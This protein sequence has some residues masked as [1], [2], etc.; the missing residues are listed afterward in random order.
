MKIVFTPESDRQASEKERWWREHRPAS[1]TLFADELS[2]VLDLIAHTPNVGA[3]YQTVSGRH[4][5]RVLMPRTKNHVYFEVD[6]AQQRV[7][8]HAVWGTPRG[9][10]PD[11]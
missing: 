10:G 7:I 6:E 1:P 4:A 11:L 5:R 3:V 2:D 8:V 9:R